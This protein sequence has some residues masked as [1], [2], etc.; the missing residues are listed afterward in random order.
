MRQILLLAGLGSALGSAFAGHFYLTRLESEVA[1]GEKVPILVAAQDTAAGTIL[2]QQQL[3][4]R[5]IPEAFLDSR[6]IRVADSKQVI[7][8]RLTVGLKA[9]QALLWS[10]L[11]TYTDHGR[12][13]SQ[14]VEKGLRAVEIDS[15]VSNFDGM[16]RPGDRVDLLLTTNEGVEGHHSTA[17]LLQNLLVLSVGGTLERK[18]EQEESGTRRFSTA[19]G[20]TVS[21]T[22]TQSQLI[23]QAKTRGVLTLALRNPDDVKVIEGLPETTDKDLNEV[24]TVTSSNGVSA[25]RK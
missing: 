3:V 22:L 9:Q 6:T 25:Q 11:A 16:L 17:T 5:D 4:V 19:R 10:D 14:L 1:G 23:T 18:P 7:G 21:A 24:L 8:Q 2:S 13:L 20:V 15:K 12:L